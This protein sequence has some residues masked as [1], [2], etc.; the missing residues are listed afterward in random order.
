MALRDELAG[1]A[2][3]HLT[4]ALTPII[5]IVPFEGAILVTA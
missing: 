3:A 2:R 4:P 1:V 5:E